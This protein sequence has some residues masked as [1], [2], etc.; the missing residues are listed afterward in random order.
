MSSERKKP[1]E[2]EDGRLWTSHD[3]LLVCAIWT[4]IKCAL[5]FCYTSTDFEVHRNWLAITSNLPLSRWYFDETSEWTLDYPPFFAYF[6]WVLSLFAR[7]VDPK[8]VTLQSAPFMSPSTLLFQRVSVVLCD[9][10]FYFGCAF[11]SE[12]VFE[13]AKESPPF[14]KRIKSLLFV[15]LAMNPSLLLLDNIHFQYN[16]M[17]YGIFC[18]AIGFLFKQQKLRVGGVEGFLQILSRLFPFKRGLTHSYWA[19]NWWAFYNAADY[20]LYRVGRLLGRASSVPRYTSGVVDTYDHVH[21]PNIHPLHTHLLVLFA[22]MPVFGVFVTRTTNKP[23]KAFVLSAFAFFMFSWHVHEKALLLVQIPMTVLALKELKFLSLSV[24]LSVCTIY[25]QLP[26]IHANPVEDVVKYS[27]AIFATVLHLAALRFAFGLEVK[28]TFSPITR[29]FCLLFGLVEGYKCFL[30]KAIFGQTA[31][32]L[33]LMLT[34]T[35]CAV[36]VFCVYF[37]V[38][39]ETFDRAAK[40]PVAKLRLLWTE[41]RAKAGGQKAD[42]GGVKFVAGVDVSAY[43][44]DQGLAIASCTIV[45]QEDEAIILDFDYVPEF[46]ALREAN[47]LARLVDRVKARFPIDLLVVDGNGEFHSRGCGAATIV[48][49]LS[50]T[51]SIG[52]AKN[53]GGLALRRFGLSDAT[54]AQVE[55]ELKQECSSCAVGSIFELKHEEKTV[56][57]AVRSSSI[58]PLFVSAGFRTGM[59][60]AIDVITTITRGNSALPIRVGSPVVNRKTKLQLCSAFLL[61][62][63]AAFN[64]LASSTTDQSENPPELKNIIVASALNARGYVTTEKKAYLSGIRVEAE[65]PGEDTFVGYTE[66]GI[67]IVQPDSVVRIVLFGWWMDE[68]ILV[69]F[70]DTDSCTDARQNVPQSD[71]TIQ[72]ERRL[73]IDYSFPNTHS[74]FKVCLKQKAREDEKNGGTIEMPYILIDDLRTSVSTD[75]PPRHYYFPMGIQIAIISVLLI[76]SA[77][78]SGLNLGLMALTPQELTL[79]SKSGSK[80]ERICAETI[81]PVRKSGN[82]LLCS[83]LIG[84]ICPQSLCV[85]KGL[86]VG[87]RTIWITRFFMVLTFPL[88]YPIS[89]ILDCVLGD[90][91]VSYDRKRLMELIKMTTASEE[92]IADELR[93]AVGAMEISDKTVEDVMTKISDVFMLSENTVLNTKTVAEILRMGYTRIPVYSGDRNNVVS[94]LFVKDLALLDPD[95]N[96]TVKTVCGYHE[97]ALRFVMYDMPLRAML[98]EFKKGL[99]HMALVSKCVQTDDHDPVYELVGIVT[100]EDIIEEILQ[101]EI[102]DETDAITDNVHRI[103]RRRAME[104][105]FTHCL[106]DNDPGACQISV[107]MQLVTMQ[108]LATNHPAF[109]ENVISYSV[110][111]KVIRQNVHKVE[112]THL[113]DTKDP[114]MVLPRSSKLYTKKEPSDKFILILEGRALVTIGQTEMTFEAGP[115]HCFG[116]ELLDR[117]HQITTTMQ[118]NQTTQSPRNSQSG[119][120]TA[121]Q[122]AN[123][124]PV[125]DLD[126]KKVTFVPDFTAIIRDD[127]TYLEISAQTYLLAYKA[128]LINKKRADGGEDLKD[129]IFDRAESQPKKELPLN[130]ITAKGQLEEDTVLVRPNGSLKRK[131]LDVRL[132]R[133]NSD[134]SALLNADGEEADGDTARTQV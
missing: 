10:L 126:M 124:V 133:A 128:T 61:V 129:G 38:L 15:L 87:A 34:S 23:L 45:H 29:L 48:G 7:L 81:L 67:S 21:L 22:L 4:A 13:N 53:F 90:E 64:P 98:E 121:V 78:F 122:N 117:L 112:L 111:E 88:A 1:K 77:L 107:Q 96:F 57:A 127:C 17:M 37:G 5:V 75:L 82:L 120:P 101:A 89:K 118:K 9:V 116:N 130:N 63:I 56:L 58:H 94:L 102:V 20:A 104:H 32:F 14:R 83:L 134:T 25:A 110:L 115:W 2:K 100:L 86:E 79:I 108:W 119:L 19:P 123:A 84:N 132:K 68:V 131:S 114:K 69:G 109:H 11:L 46:L 71:F 85:K 18:T 99:Y 59:E 50:N 65:E 95:D 6:E 55:E 35:V 113:G 93:I 52:V 92:G 74:I 66:K 30:H 51:P 44:S 49:F 39:W 125:H 47:A 27:L 91:V 72:T 54:I 60:A 62:A 41:R 76:L 24:L 3:F 16:S 70:T 97:H 33:P 42:A 105:E 26:L 43:D 28:W 73:V 40:I 103:R 36:A 106:M 8:I 31:D 12:A 80:R